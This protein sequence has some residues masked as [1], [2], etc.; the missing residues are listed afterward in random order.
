MGGVSSSTF[1]NQN[2]SWKGYV[3]D[4]NSGGF[5]GIR[6]T[7]FKTALDMTSCSGFEFTL[8]GVNVGK[9]QFKAVARDSTD[10][11][12]VCWTS[13]FG[14]GT[15]WGLWGSSNN[16]DSISNG[17]G[18]EKQIKVKI[19]FCEMVPTIFAKTVPNQSLKKDNIVGFQLVYSKF[20]YD[21]DLNP[22]FAVGDFELSVIE[23][24]AY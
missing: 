8:S 13:T 9:K 19:P 17:G 21:G 2:G 16:N 14:G 1:N 5:V 10:F 23:V 12:G 6:T 3:T 24:K 4:K 22:D 20:L 18:K 11:N 15:K 7:P